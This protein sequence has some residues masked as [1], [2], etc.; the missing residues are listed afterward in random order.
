MTRELCHPVAGVLVAAVAGQ[1]AK[2][3]GFTG[4]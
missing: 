1:K 3:R 4:K 2:L